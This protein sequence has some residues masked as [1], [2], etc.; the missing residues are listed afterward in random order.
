MGP[1][2]R[3]SVAHRQPRPPLLGEA[4]VVLE[5]VRHGA[6]VLERGPA[7]SVAAPARLGAPRSRALRAGGVDENDGAQCEPR[8]QLAMRE[9]LPRGERG[10]AHRRREALHRKASRRW[11]VGEDHVGDARHR[12]ERPREH[13]L[14]PTVQGI[15]GI[16]SSGFPAHR[17][18]KHRPEGPRVPDENP[19]R[20][21]PSCSGKA[22]AGGSAVVPPAHP[23]RVNEIQPGRRERRRDRVRRGAEI[24]SP[25]H[26]CDIARGS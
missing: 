15:D 11:L 16:P 22:L 10:E 6:G 26:G 21:R 2:D 7:G 20:A 18:Q 19:E 24:A 3:A 25:T 1:A 12:G 8:P 13:L 9:E 4:C 23:K 14:D 5:R 17:L